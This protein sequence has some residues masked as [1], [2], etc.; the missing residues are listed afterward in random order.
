MCLFICGALLW[1]GFWQGFLCGRFRSRPN[2]RLRVCICR[3]LGFG[4][5]R[6]GFWCS[7]WLLLVLVAVRFQSTYN[8]CWCSMGLDAQSFFFSP[9]VA[10]LFVFVACPYLFAAAVVAFVGAEVS[11]SALPAECAS[12]GVVG[13][14]D[15]WLFLLL[16]AEVAF[17]V[18]CCAVWV[19]VVGHVVSFF[20]YSFSLQF[21]Q[22]PSL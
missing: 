6:L 8:R 15:C 18:C 4:R 1:L 10:W 3:Y 5:G 7:E 22:F 9:V 20:W 13:F 11:A 16:A 2:C 19:L 17:A 21:L 14:Y 12:H